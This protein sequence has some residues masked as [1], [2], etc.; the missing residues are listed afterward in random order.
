MTDDVCNAQCR[1]HM[2]CVEKQGSGDFHDATQVTTARKTV[3]HWMVDY[4]L[5]IV[6]QEVIQRC[7][8]FTPPTFRHKTLQEVEDHG[9]KN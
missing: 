2:V 8:F 4:S 5:V 9:L 7:R 6:P 1:V 3:T